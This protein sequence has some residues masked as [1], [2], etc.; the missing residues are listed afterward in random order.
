MVSMRYNMDIFQF[1]RS[2]VPACAQ[3]WNYL[4]EPCFADD[5]VAAFK[6]MINRTL[7]FD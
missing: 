2:F 7:L 3:Y 4:D 5:V 6:S 1:G